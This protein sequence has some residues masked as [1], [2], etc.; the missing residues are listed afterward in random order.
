M[1]QRRDSELSAVEQQFSE[2]RVA[3]DLSRFFEASLNEKTRESTV[4]AVE[5]FLKNQGPLEK[6]DPDEKLEV[7]AITESLAVP[8]L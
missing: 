5:M 4:K 3:N 7:Q 6:L 2:Y 8:T 1:K